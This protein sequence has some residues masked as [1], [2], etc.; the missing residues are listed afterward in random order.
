MIK[1]VLF[2]LDGTLLDRDQSL[3]KFAKSQYHRYEQLH[4][5]IAEK[6]FMNRLIELD[7]KGYVPKQVVYPKLIEEFHVQGVK[8]EELVNDYFNYFHESCIAFPHV[9]EVLKDLKEKGLQLGIITN[10]RNPFQLENLKALG[11]EHYFDVILISEKEGLKKPDGRIF[12]RAL[13]KLHARPEDSVFI[14]DHPEKDVYAAIRAGMHGIWK[15][16]DYWGNVQVE[17]SIEGIE[18]LPLMMERTF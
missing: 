2:D 10:G 12:H 18:E 15:R 6:H 17:H 5:N 3:K 11:I 7:K 16:D 13:N 9:D 8:A 1:A 14:G 4:R